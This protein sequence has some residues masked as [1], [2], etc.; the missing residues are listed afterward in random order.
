MFSKIS[1]EQTEKEFPSSDS[2][3]TD[4]KIVHRNDAYHEIKL[5]HNTLGSYLIKRRDANMLKFSSDRQKTSNET[6]KILTKVIQSAKKVQ[7]I[8]LQL[9]K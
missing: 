5:K 9:E 8:D 2:L 7:K 1:S 6:L 4:Q 3:K